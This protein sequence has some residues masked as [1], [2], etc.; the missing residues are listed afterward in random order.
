M[1]NPDWAYPMIRRT[2]PKQV[3]E[4]GTV[5]I[6]LDALRK[7][8]MERSRRGSGLAMLGPD[9]TPAKRSPFH[10]A[11]AVLTGLVVG[12]AV[13]LL[14]TYFLIYAHSGEK[15]TRPVPRALE[16]QKSPGLHQPRTQIPRQAAKAAKHPPATAVTVHPA[17]RQSPPVSRQLPKSADWQIQ[18]FSWT[19]RRS[20]RYVVINMHLY[21]AGNRLP[22]GAHLLTIQRDGL[23]IE[24]RGHRYF[25]PRP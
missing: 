6:I 16:S 9:L 20:A 7:A 4:S 5:S 13:A 3:P 2:L 15:P 17:A 23:L 22:D 10:V 21:R 1:H 12:I 11:V 24:Y 14:G 8:E 25:V 18:V 19:P